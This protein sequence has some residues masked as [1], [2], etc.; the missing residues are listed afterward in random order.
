MVLNPPDSTL[1]AT[2]TVLSDSI[3]LGSPRARNAV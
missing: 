1:F 3:T 2:A